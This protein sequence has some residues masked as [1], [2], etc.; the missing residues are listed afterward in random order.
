MPRC[1][2]DLLPIAVIVPAKLNGHRR[3]APSACR[4]RRHR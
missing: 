2:P 3:R 1:A 4:A